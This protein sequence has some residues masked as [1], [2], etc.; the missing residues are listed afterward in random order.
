M[1]PVPM[2]PMLG[3][4][5][6]MAVLQQLMDAGGLFNIPDIFPLPSRDELRAM[7][8]MQLNRTVSQ[9][10]FRHGIRS[11]TTTTRRRA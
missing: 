9:N 10:I 6:P 11:F 2:K 8:L 5:F 1:L 4:S 3:G 7:M